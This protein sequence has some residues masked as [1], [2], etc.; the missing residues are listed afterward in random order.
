MASLW[1][2]P[3]RPESGGMNKKMVRFFRAILGAA[4]RIDPLQCSRMPDYSNLR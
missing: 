1:L 3:R 2:S 4:A